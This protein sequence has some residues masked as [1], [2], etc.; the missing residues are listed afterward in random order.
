MANPP[1]YSPGYD[2]SA[3]E[4]SNP[5]KPKPGLQLDNDFANLG[6]AYN[7]LRDMLME[8][9]RSDGALLNG[10]VKPDALSAEVLGM[11]VNYA[12][13]ELIVQLTSRLDQ[14][15]Q[16]VIT[17][18][19]TAAAAGAVAATAKT[20]ADDAARTKS[21]PYTAFAS[22]AAALGAEKPADLRSVSALSGGVLTEWVRDT[23]GT[24]LGGGWSPAGAPSPEHW[25]A[26]GNGVANDTA[27][28]QAAINALPSAG[29]TIRL[30]KA[31]YIVTLPLTA[32]VKK[33]LWTGGARINGGV[34]PKLPGT[35]ESYD[36][37]NSRRVVSRADAGSG[38]FV[39]TDHYRETSYG[40]AD[41]S[42][43]TLLRAYTIVS[44]GSSTIGSRPGAEW[45]FQAR[46]DNNSDSIN[47]VASTGQ[48]RRYGKG[49]V[50]SGHFNTYDYIDPT[51]ST[52]GV[53]GIE[54]NIQ[55]DG[56]DPG[57]MRRVIG[58]IAH[59]VA[60]TY[61][62]SGVNVIGRG[63]MINPDSAD[64]T[65]GLHVLT[66]SGAGT[67]RGQ[68]LSAAIRIDAVAP[69]LIAARH[70]TATG[71]VKIGTNLSS[72]IAAQI[73]GVGNNA[74]DQSASYSMIRTT[75]TTNTAG[76]EAANL[77]LFTA[78]AG[79]LTEML[80][81]S[82][83]EGLRIRMDG[84]LKHVTQGAADSAGSGYRQ[85]RVIN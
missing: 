53:W 71:T 51:T 55:G 30:N 13:D 34:Y 10:I 56:G 66:G 7:T 8:L 16:D 6:Q 41:P 58:A 73:I 64:F 19:G 20:T 29:G 11:L 77:A 74:S 59:S 80:R 49:A 44:A 79:T 2:Y 42:V 82:A 38:E 72:G 47:G 40:A 81:V 14:V 3:F 15:T 60:Q 17:A 25:G 85:L 78:S 46:V 45:P 62:G 67:T 35:F 57:N 18:Q 5:T 23:A 76:A 83:A 21:P 52:F 75:I 36:P 68:F 28:F 9:R 69:D 31:N 50:W 61:G 39:Q 32:G 48:A 84:V 33:I 27:A 43:D 65:Y 24:C 1:P 4:N 37:A 70:P 12:P 22:Y 63:V 54:A 26:V